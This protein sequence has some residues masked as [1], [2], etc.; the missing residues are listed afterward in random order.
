M[1]WH[2]CEQTAHQNNKSPSD[3]KNKTDEIEVYDG[4]NESS[5]I[6]LKKNSVFL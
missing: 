3:P 5:S 2:L 6:S 1:I 4:K